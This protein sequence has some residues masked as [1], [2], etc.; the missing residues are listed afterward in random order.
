GTAAASTIWRANEKLQGSTFNPQRSVNVQHTSSNQQLPRFFHRL[1]IRGLEILWVLVVEA[2][3]F[4]SPVPRF[5]N[6]LQCCSN[7]A[8]ERRHCSHRFRRNA[9][10]WQSVD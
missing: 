8:S 5:N 1:A 2:W 9:S 6:P 7:I 10:Q 4:C 3:T